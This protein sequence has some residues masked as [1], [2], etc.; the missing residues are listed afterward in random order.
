MPSDGTFSKVLFSQRKTMEAATVR[1]L[2]E[3]DDVN[4]AV[5]DMGFKVSPVPGT[6]PSEQALRS[7]RN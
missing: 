6:R 3:I 5:A 1:R 7:D 2:A 4:L